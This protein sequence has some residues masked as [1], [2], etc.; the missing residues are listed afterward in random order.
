MK[1][2]SI[3]RVFIIR[4]IITVLKTPAHIIK[5]FVI[6][7]DF[8]YSFL[9]DRVQEAAKSAI[10]EALKTQMHL[11]IGLFLRDKINSLE[12]DVIPFHPMLCICPSLPFTFSAT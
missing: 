2:L 5:G 7:R 9:H 11:Q 8:K 6:R 12:Q 3:Y 1:V 10:P 4:N